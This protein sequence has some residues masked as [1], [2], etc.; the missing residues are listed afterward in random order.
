[1]N[2]LEI[3]NHLLAK[4]VDPLI[5]DKAKVLSEI[6][7]LFKQLLNSSE[8][9]YYCSKCQGNHFTGKTYQ[10]H[11]KNLDIS[12]LFPS[13]PTR[14]P[15]TIHYQQI[16]GIYYTGN[17]HILERLPK[18]TIFILKPE[19]NN[20]HDSHAVSVWYERDRIGYIPRHSN[21]A[22]FNAL[23]N[24]KVTCMFGKYRPSFS[25]RGSYWDYDRDST[26][27]PERA[28]ITIHIFNP[29]K[30]NEILKGFIGMIS[31]SNNFTDYQD[32]IVEA[33]YILGYRAIKIL[34]NQR[35]T[36]NM[37]EILSKLYD[38]FKIQI[39]DSEFSILL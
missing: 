2:E 23:S 35:Q 36:A 13:I 25:S 32:K 4:F 31:V 12:P 6:L 28:D 30:F 11:K 15:D 39:K 20:R 1:M 16:V 27:S 33:L 26:F 37:K 5:T 19:P 22:V 18:G 17:G 21:K 24:E 10:N 14:S 3:Y 7:P 38:K 9:P 8:V 34:E 29:Q